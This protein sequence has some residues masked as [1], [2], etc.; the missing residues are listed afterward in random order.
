MV[1]VGGGASGE[2]AVTPCPGPVVSGEW[3]HPGE[4]GRSGACSSRAVW[5]EGLLPPAA[6]TLSCP[7]GRALG[8]F[9]LTQLTF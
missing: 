7:E 2:D 6:P 1:C 3:H 5:A 9:V 4:T 8:R